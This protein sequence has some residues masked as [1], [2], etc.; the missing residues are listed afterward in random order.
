MHTGCIS[1]SLQVVK[2]PAV[3]LRLKVNNGICEVCQPD[4]IVW[5]QELTAL[6]SHL[7]VEEKPELYFI[8]NWC[9][10]FP[11][12]TASVKYPELFFFRFSPGEQFKSCITIAEFSLRCVYGLC[13]SISR[14][15]NKKTVGTHQRNAT[16]CCSIKKS[17]T[18]TTI[19]EHPRHQR[20]LIS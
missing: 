1:C 13:I 16:F 9:L 6:F 7:E 12:L 10:C 20:N 15:I 5:Y 4:Y 17:K 3:I 8:R 14:I 11:N 18:L 2:S 19:I